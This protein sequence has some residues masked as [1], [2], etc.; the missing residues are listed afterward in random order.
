MSSRTK[1]IGVPTL[2][3]LMF[4]LAL[5]VLSWG[6]EVKPIGSITAIEGKVWLAHGGDKA[7]YP[8]ILGDLIYLYDHI[9]T[10]IA[11]RVQI[12]FEDER[13]LNL[14]ENTTIQIK[15]HIYSPEENRRSVV[16]RVLMGRVRGVVGRRCMGRGSR[17]IISTPT[18]TIEVQHGR[19]VVD[20]LQ[21]GSNKSF[22][23]QLPT[24]FPPKSPRPP[25][26]SL[27]PRFRSRCTAG[28]W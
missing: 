10:E 8:A 27:D 7:S 23:L 16:I 9:Q 13:L 2:T 20:A 22:S 12:L 26:V 11:S 21:D 25:P 18:D 28:F 5:S 6:A 3:G 24:T 17:Y 4:L 19:F 15:E 1:K 14:A